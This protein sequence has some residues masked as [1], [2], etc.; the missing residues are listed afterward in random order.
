VACLAG[1]SRPHL[2]SFRRSRVD[3]KEA[4]KMLLVTGLAWPLSA[5]TSAPHHSALPFVFSAHP[6]HETEELAHPSACLAGPNGMWGK[7]ACEEL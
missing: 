3:S 6:P 7:G 5:R 2:Q 4:R 1:P